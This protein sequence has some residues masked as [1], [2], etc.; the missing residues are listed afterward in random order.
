MN[1]FSGYFGRW[2]LDSS[3]V[4]FALHDTNVCED[5]NEFL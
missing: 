2:G 4:F 1:I 5:K 3:E